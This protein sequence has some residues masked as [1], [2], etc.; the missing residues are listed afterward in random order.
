[1]FRG[2]Y[3]GGSFSSSGG[4]NLGLWSAGQP[5][6]IFLSVRRLGWISVNGNST[7][8]TLA[9]AENIVQ[10]QLEKFGDGFLYNK[11]VPED[12]LSQ[13]DPLNPPI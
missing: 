4:S 9:S 2:V 3:T 6:A 11:I 13:I 8:T 1:V 5:D 10:V 7:S 12:K